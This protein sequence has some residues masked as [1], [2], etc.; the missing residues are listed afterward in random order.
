MLNT[1]TTQLQCKIH[2]PWLFFLSLSLLNQR[3]I[4]VSASGLS[5]GISN[6]HEEG[7]FDN[8]LYFHGFHFKSQTK[9][10]K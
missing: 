2:L 8:W 4:C 6:E 9:L 10:S 5:I 1:R 3:V 7:D